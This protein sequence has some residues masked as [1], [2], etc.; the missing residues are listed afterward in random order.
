MMVVAG[1]G[2]ALLMGKHAEAYGVAVTEKPSVVMDFF[3]NR[4]ELRP[5]ML[6]GFC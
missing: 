1:V 6:S 2:L 5:R 4:A 3:H